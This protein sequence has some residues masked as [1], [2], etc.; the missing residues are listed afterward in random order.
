MATSYLLQL[1]HNQ[2]IYLQQQYM[3]L[4]P[5]CREEVRISLPKQQ[6]QSHHQIC[7][8]VEE[9]FHELQLLLI[10]PEL[11]PQTTTFGSAVCS[12]ATS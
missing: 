9:E 1:L 3:E 12:N 2:N 6:W 11:L 10:L 8:M 5:Y 4:A 7:V